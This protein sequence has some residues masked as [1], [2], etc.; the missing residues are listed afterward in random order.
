MCTIKFNL[1]VS[2]MVESDEIDW[3][4]SR[5]RK[6]KLTDVSRDFSDG[7]KH[8]YNIYV[9]YISCSLFSVLT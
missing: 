6:A 5:L 9:Y 7:N 8:I 4:N 1:T 3:V 2:D